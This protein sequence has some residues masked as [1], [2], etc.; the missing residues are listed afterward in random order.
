ME[1]RLQRRKHNN[2]NNVNEA[3]TTV[4][5][6]VV[7]VTATTPTTMVTAQTSMAATAAAMVA[8]KVTERACSDGDGTVLETS[9]SEHFPSDAVVL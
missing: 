5:E 1:L 7:T 6:A 2:G 4:A 9:C 8:E 3:A